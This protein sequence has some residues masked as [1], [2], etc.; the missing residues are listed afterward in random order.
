MAFTF[1]SWVPESPQDIR[2]W[3]G[4]AS[5][6]VMATVPALPVILLPLSICSALQVP[7][8]H[9]PALCLGI[10]S[11]C[12]A[13]KIQDMASLGQEGGPLWPIWRRF[14]RERER[15]KKG[16]QAGMYQGLLVPL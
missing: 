5:L 4:W 15:R 14:G 6:T 9:M 1:P 8:T 3:A 13:R 12:Q 11:S 7:Y 2:Q 16:R 10:W